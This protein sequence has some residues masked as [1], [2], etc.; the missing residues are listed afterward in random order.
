MCLPKTGVPMGVQMSCP[1]TKNPSAFPV[2]HVKRG[3]A[4]R[5]RRGEVDS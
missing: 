5:P 2:F 1:G 3:R 4:D